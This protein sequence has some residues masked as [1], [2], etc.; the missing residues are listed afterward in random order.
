MAT[1]GSLLYFV[2]ADLALVDPM[3]Q[4]SLLY[5]TRCAARCLYLM[6]SSVGIVFLESCAHLLLSLYFL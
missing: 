1:L 3:Y 4:Y 2:V 5:Y 6:H